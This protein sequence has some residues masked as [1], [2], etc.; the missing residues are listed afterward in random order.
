[1]P[2]C[3]TLLC[4]YGNTERLYECYDTNKTCQ[5]KP[6]PREELEE[7]GQR[8]ERA[9]REEEDAVEEVESINDHINGYKHLYDYAV[10]G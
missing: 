2:A 5:N 8:E 1:V 3:L 7:N 9:L 10:I 4:N 6:I